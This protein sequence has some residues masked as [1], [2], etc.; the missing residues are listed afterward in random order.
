VVLDDVVV[1]VVTCVVLVLDDG[2]EGLV[3][4]DVLDPLQAIRLVPAA[5]VRTSR[6]TVCRHF[7]ILPVVPPGSLTR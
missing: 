7:T 5:R 3:V 6:P 4:G 2:E 1:D